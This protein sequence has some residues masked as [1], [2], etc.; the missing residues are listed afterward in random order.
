MAGSALVL[1]VNQVAAKSCFV[2]KETSCDQP[3]VLVLLDV[4]QPDL[5]GGGGFVPRERTLTKEKETRKQQRYL[6]ISRAA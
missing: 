1:Y 4:K 6:E 3:T 2:F 5:V